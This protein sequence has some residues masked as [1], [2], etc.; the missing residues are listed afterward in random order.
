MLPAADVTTPPATPRRMSAAVAA[1]TAATSATGHL[2]VSVS[3]GAAT[4][5]PAEPPE[6]LLRRADHALLA[7]KRRSRYRPRNP[8][9]DPIA[10]TMIAGVGRSSVSRNISRWRERKRV[11]WRNAVLAGVEQADAFRR[12]GHQFWLHVRGEPGGAAAA[13]SRGT[14]KERTNIARRRLVSLYWRRGVW[15]PGTSHWPPR[16]P[17]RASVS[18]LTTRGAHRPGRLAFAARTLRERARGGTPGGHHP[19]HFLSRR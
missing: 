18:S 14:R 9:T 12:G 17:T 3:V 5:R 1:I 11:Q 15:C 16:P 8:P 2:P 7:A 4:S 19:R 10:R 6:S 13:S